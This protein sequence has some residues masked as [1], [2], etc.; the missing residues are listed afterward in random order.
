MLL[1]TRRCLINC[2]LSYRTGMLKKF[3]VFTTLKHEARL[4]VQ[5]KHH[6]PGVT[7]LAKVL[8]CW[9]WAAVSTQA[10]D[11]QFL[12]HAF[13]QKSS[14]LVLSALCY[15]WHVFSNHLF[16][17]TV[18]FP[19]ILIPNFS[20]KS[21]NKTLCILIYHFKFHA[22]FWKVRYQVKHSRDLFFIFCPLVASIFFMI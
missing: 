18:L 16:F 19:Q 12:R 21:F 3:E 20:L 10:L 14:C 17:H 5:V 4:Q 6:K 22:K 11:G 2:L 1:L 8:S 15:T 9:T 7:S 13:S